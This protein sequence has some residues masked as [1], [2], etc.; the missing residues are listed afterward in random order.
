MP[1]IDGCETTRSIRA[2]N[3]ASQ[4]Q[5]AIVTAYGR[6]EVRE[7]AAEVDV[8]LVLTKPIT[9]SVMFN[10]LMQM[11]SGSAAQALAPATSESSLLLERLRKLRG[12]RVL[13]AEDN[14]I[15]QLVATELL[16]DAGFS[17]EVAENGRI[18]VDMAQARPYDLVLMDMQMPEMDGLEACRLIKAMPALAQLP[19]I[20][21]TANAMQADRQRCLDAGM[22]DF[23]SKPIDTDA[24]WGTLLQWIKPQRPQSQALEPEQPRQEPP[25]VQILDGVEDFDAAS[26][27]RR[28]LGREDLY[29]DMLRRFTSSY[30]E[31]LTPLREAVTT[32]DLATAERL[33]HTLRGVSATIGATRVPG[34]AGALEEEV[35]GGAPTP[36]LFELVEDLVACVARL[37]RQLQAALGDDAHAE[38]APPAVTAVSHQQQEALLRRLEDLLQDSDGQADALLREQESALRVILT[39]RFDK[40]SAAVSAF[41]F[42]RALLLLRAAA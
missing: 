12:A 10:A 18:A 6:E 41:D 20:A 28:V 11:L 13:L 26:G 19:V 7:Q 34:L 32:G 24:L 36:R 4:P 8:G 21:M 35:R 17:V 29:R 27:L 1:G 5:I 33:A 25:P 2:M 31:G 16:K 38:V 14:E 23:I 40:L 22:V 30:G 9:A 3:I 37:T 42:D 15:N 39:S